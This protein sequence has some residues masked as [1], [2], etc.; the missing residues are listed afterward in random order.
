MKAAFAKVRYFFTHAG[1]MSARFALV[2]FGLRAGGS[3]KRQRGG[4]HGLR[5]LFSTSFID[6]V[7]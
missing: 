4:G 1:R 6:R 2:R 7:A 5:D 3:G